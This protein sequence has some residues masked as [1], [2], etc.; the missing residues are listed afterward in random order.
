MKVQ[1]ISLC[2]KRFPP[3]RGTETGIVK[4][5][6]A[7]PYIN[8]CINLKQVKVHQDMDLTSQVVSYKTRSQQSTFRKRDTMSSS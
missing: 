7:Q 2:S 1:W 5:F 6:Q 8:A 4:G 3:E